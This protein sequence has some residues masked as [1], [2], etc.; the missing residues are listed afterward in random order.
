MTWPVIV[1]PCVRL[2]AP[3]NAR[4]MGVRAPLRMTAS[5]AILVAHFNLGSGREGCA[6]FGDLVEKWRRPPMRAELFLPGDDLLVD[7]LWSGRVAPP[8]RAAT[9][10]R[11]AEAEDPHDVDVAGPQRDAVAEKL[12][13]LVDEREHAALDDLLVLD[14]AALDAEPLRLGGDE[15]VDPG[16]LNRFALPV[17]VDE[18][19]LPGFLPVAPLLVQSGRDLRRP[20]RCLR[21]FQADLVEDVD[22]REIAHPEGSHREAKVF[23]RSVD[24]HRRRAL[25]EQK[26]RLA[27]V[28]EEHTVADEAEGVAGDDAL[29]AQA[30]RE[31]RRRYERFVR[32][33]LSAHDLE[34]LHVVRRRE[35][36]KPH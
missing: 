21:R 2:K 28:V 22:A 5:F 35:E 18:E 27:D 7:V 26:V 6:A 14:P 30:F 20:V 13:A 34:Q 25:F 36:V 12:R 32:S 31:R 10:P 15:V 29:L 9:I 8:H 1:A 11:E 4:P 16:I 23:H 17:L 19:A 24:L 3:R 33:G